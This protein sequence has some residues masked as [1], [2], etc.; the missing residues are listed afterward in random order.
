[1]YAH[2]EGEI[3]RRNIGLA[4][5]GNALAMHAFEPPA[6][7]R[8]Q[9][10]WTRA[11]HAISFLVENTM[12]DMGVEVRRA[13]PSRGK[14][15]APPILSHEFVIQNHGDIM[16]CILVV[17]AVGFFFSQTTPLSA[18]FVLPQ[19]NETVALPTDAEPQ[20]YYRAGRL[21]IPSIVFYSIVWIT[22]HCL[23]QEYVLDKV[24]RRLHMSKTRMSKFDESGQLAAFGFYSAL[25]AGYLIYELAIYKD[26]TSLWVGYP[27]THR[28][29]TF[30]VKYFFLLHI[31]YWLHQY[32]EFYFQKVRN[33]EIAPRTIYITAYL[34][35]SAAAYFTA[36][37]RVGLLLLFIEGLLLAIFHTTRALYFSG[38]ITDTVTG[39]KP[40]NVA[41]PSLRF[42]SVVL[43][44]LSFWYG[45]RTVEVPFIDVDATNFNTS[46][47]R[48]NTLIVILGLQ[49]YSLW[50]YF[51]FHFSR[52]RERNNNKARSS[53]AKK[54]K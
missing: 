19:Y 3:R 1:M 44:V 8:Q 51:V 16:S 52:F 32:P 2:H 41:F 38:K 40:Y 25:H 17:I 37:I 48:L 10:A 12:S 14:K 9:T 27:D 13:V 50:N 28:Y 39:F 54:Q 20:T 24:H 11:R 42:I 22:V 18:L 33:E 35:V 7:H 15:A 36:F 6:A 23:L 30:N 31:A 46:L 26:I 47:F 29:M 21:D 45:F 4:L 43:T 34:V 5:D 53:K 49:V